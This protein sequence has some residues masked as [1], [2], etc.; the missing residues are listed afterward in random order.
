VLEVA[1]TPR[2]PYRLRDSLGVPDP[3]RRAHGGV[4]DLAY[5]TDGG[6]AAARVWQRIDGTLRAVINAAD[7]EAAHDRLVALLGIRLDTRPF[8]R[9]A[10]ADPL[11]APL[12]KRL[13]GLRPMVLGTPAH[14]LIRAV[15]GQRIRTSEA[16]AIERR[17]LRR[18]GTPHAG[19]VLPPAAALI[20]R[21]HPGQFERAGLSPMRAAALTRAARR[22]RLDALPADPAGIALRRITREPGLGAWSAGVLLVYGFGRHEHGLAGDLS[23]VRLARALG[24]DDDAALLQRYGPWQGLASLWLMRH[25]LAA[26]HALAG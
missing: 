12:W 26:R 7:E 5:P 4:L 3:T 19:L 18:L 1:L 15:C 17:I 23:L 20:A 6:P 14:A 16:L 10:A 2:A 11:L 24:Q 8:L 25:P 21:T 22:L 9:M 13:R